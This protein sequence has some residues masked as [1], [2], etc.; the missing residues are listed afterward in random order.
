M[1]ERP[2]AGCCGYAEVAAMENYPEQ[3]RQSHG[4]RQTTSPQAAPL[5]DPHRTHSLQMN[6]C[7][8]TLGMRLASQCPTPTNRG[9]GEGRKLVTSLK[10]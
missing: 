7:W 3:E 5:K 4:G 6:H 10:I 9:R 2:L 1:A 8:R